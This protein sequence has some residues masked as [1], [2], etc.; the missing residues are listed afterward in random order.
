M[1]FHIF[2]PC[3]RPL[4]QPNTTSCFTKKSDLLEA[5]M[6]HFQSLHSRQHLLPNRVNGLLK[7]LGV[8][9]RHVGIHAL[10]SHRKKIHERLPRRTL[11][12]PECPRPM[13]L[14]HGPGL[15]P[16]FLG[17]LLCQRHAEID[18]IRIELPVLLRIQRTGE[19]QRRQLRDRVRG[20]SL[21]FSG[22]WGK[23]CVEIEDIR[24]WFEIWGEEICLAFGVGVFPDY[25][26]TG[27]LESHNLP[28]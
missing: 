26:H 27:P 4:L 15:R 22:G 19:R 21:R 8:P 11:R 18:Q 1:C 2:A 16:R 7:L 24:V 9:S 12:M 5:D 23:R 13:N 14:R 3:T 28:I 10:P 6:F 20:K 17:Q 25:F